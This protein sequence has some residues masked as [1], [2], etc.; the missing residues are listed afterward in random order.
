M[1]VCH[2]KTKSKI[3]WLGFFGF[4]SNHHFCII[5]AM[6]DLA[7]YISTIENNHSFPNEEHMARMLQ[8]RE[9]IR[10]A[11]GRILEELKLHRQKILEG[12]IK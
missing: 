6:Q 4:K 12:E 5:N 3:G 11:R 7:I 1:F 9:K 2:E 8:N 10:E